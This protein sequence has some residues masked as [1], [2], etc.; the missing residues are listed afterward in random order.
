MLI[1]DDNCIINLEMAAMR[2][3]DY[4]KN[5]RRPFENFVIIR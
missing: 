5:E 1:V 3:D 4:Y 2:I